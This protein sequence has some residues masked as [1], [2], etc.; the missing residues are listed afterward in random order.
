MYR[1]EQLVTDKITPI[2]ESDLRP[3]SND[4]RFGENGIAALTVY[5]ADNH[6]SYINHGLEIVKGL[7]YISTFSLEY[8]PFDLRTKAWAEA[9]ERTFIDRNV[10]FFEGYL[11]KLLDRESVDIQHILST[12]N[13]YGSAEPHHYFGLARNI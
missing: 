7:S 1:A 13:M 3:A 2:L 9:Y 5:A 10:T 4:P 6:E 12:V 8:L 11:A